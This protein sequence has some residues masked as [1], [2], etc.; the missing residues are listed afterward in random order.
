MIDKRLLDSEIKNIEIEITDLGNRVT[1]IPEVEEFLEQ[2]NISR[3]KDQKV[4]KINDDVYI[5]TYL[6]RVYIKRDVKDY[7]IN[8]VK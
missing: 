2:Y 8:G 5:S 7:I 1:I 3:N 4:F 6:E